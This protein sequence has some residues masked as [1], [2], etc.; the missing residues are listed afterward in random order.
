MRAPASRRTFDWPV[1]HDWRL[2]LARVTSAD[3]LD[4][5]D[6]V[7]CISSTGAWTGRI[8]NADDDSYDMPAVTS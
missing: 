6:R 4:T 8:S 5:L 1:F 2:H 3:N 7:S